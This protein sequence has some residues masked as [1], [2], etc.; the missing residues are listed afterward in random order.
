[1][2]STSKH[3]KISTSSTRKARAPKETK[4]EHD[5]H[6]LEWIERHRQR[7]GL[8]GAELSRQLCD[9]PAWLANIKR[10]PDLKR[11][12]AP[13]RVNAEELIKLGQ[14]FGEKFSEAGG[15]NK[16]IVNINNSDRIVT[17]GENITIDYKGHNTMQAGQRTEIPRSP[18]ERYLDMPQEAMLIE[19]DSAAP[20]AREGTYVLVVDY[21][22]VRSWPLVGDEIVLKRYH[23][24]LFKQGDL[25]QSENTVRIVTRVD[26][27]LVFRAPAGNQTIKDVPY[28]P[29]DAS[30]VVQKL[31]IGYARY[32][33]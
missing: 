18:V 16:V 11:N 26:R 28:D 21:S 33:P 20:L 31:I 4:S 8:S 22:L 29:E 23:P 17:R 32:N 10:K 27:K 2:K 13:R 6:V 15:Q 24:V 19:D 25:T 12:R 7:L 1:M 5:K 30:V 14:L 3:E 9:D